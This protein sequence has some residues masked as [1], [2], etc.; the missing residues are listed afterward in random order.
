MLK[1][2]S[3]ITAL[4]ILTLLAWPQAASA[5]ELERRVQNHLARVRDFDERRRELEKV[6]L[7]RLRGAKLASELRDQ[8]EREQEKNRAQFALTRKKEDPLADE[9]REALYQAE[10]KRRDQEHEKNR[11]AFVKERERIETAI[12]RLKQIDPMVELDLPMTP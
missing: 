4:F 1:T 6:H 12:S 3:L 5:D 9:K 8:R 7:E 10:L 11:I 2:P